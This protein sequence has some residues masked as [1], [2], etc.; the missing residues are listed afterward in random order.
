[1]ASLLK[2]AMRLGLK[3]GNLGNTVS[4]LADIKQNPLGA[5]TG[6]PAGEEY[7]KTKAGQDIEGSKT[8]ISDK[9]CEQIT[10]VFE[11]RG[12]EFVDNVKQ[13]ISSEFDK[14]KDNSIQ[15]LLVEK[16]SSVLNKAILKI[17]TDI[18]N[19]QGKFICSMKGKVSDLTEKVLDKTLGASVNK[20]VSDVVTEADSSVKDKICEKHM[21]GGNNR[22]YNNEDLMRLQD[23]IQMRENNIPYHTLT[24][25]PMG[26][27]M[28]NLQQMPE[29]CGM[30]KAPEENRLILIT[31]D[32][33]TYPSMFQNSPD[34]VA[35]SSRPNL[36][37]TLRPTGSM[38][39]S[40]VHKIK[41]LKT[42]KNKKPIHNF[43]KL[44]KQK[45]KSKRHTKK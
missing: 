4:G 13:I 34:P 32:Q 36:A 1:M 8:F 45:N 15:D 7:S 38:F 17:G 35:R 21:S 20:A 6:A 9:I 43:K 3:N 30:M 19:N 28:A 29:H 37:E 12:E 23:L 27:P 14:I 41:R 16:M 42:K 18:E 11:T 2:G 44:S 26:V 25:P 39:L 5:L 22:K 31:N 24:E 10:K 33:E 40:S